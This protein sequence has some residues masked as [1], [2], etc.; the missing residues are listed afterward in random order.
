MKV[1]V[2]GSW[3]HKNQIKE[4]TEYIE[5][6][7]GVESTSSWLGMTLTEADVDKVKPQSLIDVDYQDV[8]RADVLVLVNATDLGSPSPGKWIELGYALASG[9][10]CIVW[11]NSQT[12]LFLQ[13]KFVIWL[14]NDNRAE[15]VL[16]LIAVKT[17][18]A[19]LNLGDDSAYRTDAGVLKGLGRSPASDGL[20]KDRSEGTRPG[21][22]EREGSTLRDLVRA[23]R[24]RA[25]RVARD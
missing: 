13:D 22:R 1:Y 19:T 7:A 21:I 12:S 2:S 4:L 11:G 5:R 9:K 16:A 3:S 14:P 24:S 6:M 15:L 8:E 25:A 18:L 17:T 10:L 23:I 20:D